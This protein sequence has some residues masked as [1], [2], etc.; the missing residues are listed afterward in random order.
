MLTVKN[1]IQ[2][3]KFNNYQMWHVFFFL[4]KKWGNR[5]TRNHCCLPKLLIPSFPRLGQHL[6]DAVSP[7]FLYFCT[8]TVWMC[9]QNKVL[10]SNS[11]FHISINSIHDPYPFIQY[12]NLETCPQSKFIPFSSIALFCWMNMLYLSVLSLLGM[13][14]KFCC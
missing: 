14:L 13:P 10:H 11:Y 12:Y 1:N 5:F 3:A 2:N 9:M 7:A 6:Q 8:F 4:R